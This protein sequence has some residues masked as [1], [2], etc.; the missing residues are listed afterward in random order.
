MQRC[1]VG[2]GVGVGVGVRCWVEA[3]GVGARWVE[4][5]RAPAYCWNRGRCF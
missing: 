3:G 5:D 4:Q 1:V 2:V